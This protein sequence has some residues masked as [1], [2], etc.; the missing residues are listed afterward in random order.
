MRGFL[1]REEGSLTLLSLIFF[2]LMFLIGGLAVD[3]LVF[4]NNR[5][6]LQN[7]SDRA[8]LA[9]ADLDQ[10]LDAEAVVQSY[11][12]KEG[13]GVYIDDV[14]VVDN[15]AAKSVQV[16]ATK[17][18]KTMFMRMVGTTDLSAPANAMATEAAGNVEISLVLDNSGSMGSI[19]GN[20]GKTRLEKLK[21]AVDTFL[22]VMYPEGPNEQITVSIV[23]YASQVNAGPT[24]TNLLNVTAEHTYSDCIEFAESDFGSLSLDTQIQYARSAHFDMYGSQ[25]TPSVFK[26]RPDSEQQVYVM[27]TDPSVIQTRVNALSAQGWTSLDLGAKWGAALLDP[28]SNTLVQAL[29]DNPNTGVKAVHA[30]RPATYSDGKTVKALILMTDGINTE[31]QNM[32]PAKKDGASDLWRAQGTIAEILAVDGLN[33]LP[34]L[35]SLVNAGLD[36]NLVRTWYTRKVQEGSGHDEDGD[37]QEN[38]QFWTR[39]VVIDGVTVVPEQWSAEVLEGAG[40]AVPALTWPEVWADF[41]PKYYANKFIY[42]PFNDSAARDAFMGDLYIPVTPTTKD[43]RLDTLCTKARTDGLT[44]YTVGLSVN[45]HART[46]LQNCATNV[47]FFL[48]A[49]SDNL[50]D[51]FQAIAESIV[52]QKLR[53]VQ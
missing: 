41:T 44:V 39:K 38:E 51:K 52:N 43:S 7:L 12:D 14:I 40:P 34:S 22:T 45:R 29:V 27:G 31:T 6:R 47:N 49:S 53:L 46:V 42:E 13:L 18:L 20:D 35:T 21:E 26:C 10:T 2:I 19:D 23:P 3:M 11:F 1:H 16:E 24:L 37:G 36:V 25:Q 30:A 50:A 17:N 33:N 9:A 8:T 28:S 4:E 15:G 48:D 32:N 5:T